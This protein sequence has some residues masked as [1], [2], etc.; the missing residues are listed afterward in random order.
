M[1]DDVFNGYRAFV[2]GWNLQTTLEDRLQLVGFYVNVHV[3]ASSQEQAERKVLRLVANDLRERSSNDIGD[4]PSIQV[5]EIFRM[6]Q[7]RWTE[8]DVE[9]YVFFESTEDD[10]EESLADVLLKPVLNIWNSIMFWFK[11]YRRLNPLGKKTVVELD[12]SL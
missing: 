10:D 3:N 8:E 6:R 1:G 9:Q 7:G 5:I 11:G 2:Q 4:L 12:G